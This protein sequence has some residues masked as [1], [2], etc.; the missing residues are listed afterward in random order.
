MTSRG[1]FI[2]V[3]MIDIRFFPRYLANP[4]VFVKPAAESR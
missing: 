3:G 2:F 4:A 1:R